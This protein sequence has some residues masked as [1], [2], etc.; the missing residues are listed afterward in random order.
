MS[1]PNNQVNSPIDV[2]SNGQSNSQSNGQFNGQSNGQLLVTTLLQPKL[3][4]KVVPAK[5]PD[6]AS[7]SPRSRQSIALISVHGDPA[8]EIGREEAGGQNVYVREVGEA[9]AK[10]GWQVDMFTRKSHADQPN[11]VHHAPGCRTIRLT[12]GPTEFIARDHLFQYLPEFVEAFQKFQ[13]KEGTNYPLVHTNY[14]MSAWVGLQLKQRSNIQLI[15]TY[16][17]LGSVKYRAVEQKPAIAETRLQVERAI[18]EDGDCVVSTSPQE[19]EHLRSW[20]SQDGYIEIIPC[21]TDIERF[22]RQSK[23]DARHQLGFGPQESIVL[24]VG[25]FD[26]RKGI[27]TLVRA[28]AQSQA[29]LSPTEANQRKLV[30]VGGSDPHHID[31]QERCRIEQLIQELG[32]ADR[33]VFAGQIG[34][35]RLPLYYTSADVCVIPSHYE[36]FGLVAVE[37]MACGTP[38]VASDVGGLKFTV[39]PEETGLLVPPQDVDGFAHAIDRLLTDDLWTQKLRRQAAA[40]VQQNFSWAGVGAQLSDLYRRMLAQSLSHSSLIKAS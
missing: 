7:S 29:Q 8:I 22:H 19:L 21:G 5:F 34:H 1:K 40:R 20:V 10:L 3:Q 14:W 38:V 6:N 13:T 11:I 33:T 32:I 26:P 35:D 39:I 37:A 2:Q 12:A 9:L 36:P 24:Y 4:A 16:H 31:G 17:S 23:A 25:R 30:I 27:E 28:F 15:H 18:L